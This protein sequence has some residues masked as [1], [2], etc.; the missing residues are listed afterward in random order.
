[1][2]TEAIEDLLLLKD[3]CLPFDATAIRLN[4]SPIAIVLEYLERM[5]TGGRFRMAASALMVIRVSGVKRNKIVN[6][7]IEII[8]YKDLRVICDTSYKN[9]RNDSVIAVSDTPNRQDDR[10]MERH[11]C[12]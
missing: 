12:K 11:G 6:S 1:M 4:S 5:I 2:F 9:D 7:T 10:S 3:G 8:E